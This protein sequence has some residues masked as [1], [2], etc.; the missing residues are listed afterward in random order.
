MCCTLKQD[1]SS[2]LYHIVRSRALVTYSAWILVRRDTW[3]T[4]FSIRITSGFVCCLFYDRVSFCS[5]TRL[6]L[7]LYPSL[8]SNSK[9]CFCYHLSAAIPACI[10]PGRLLLWFV[11]IGLYSVKPILI[12]WASSQGKYVVPSIM[13]KPPGFVCLVQ[14]FFLVCSSLALCLMVVGDVAHLEECLPSM[15]KALR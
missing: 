3:I 13:G 7:F 9:S 12:S 15:H 5:S 14:N 2:I 8:P 6:E 11:L 4:L 10:M 1:M